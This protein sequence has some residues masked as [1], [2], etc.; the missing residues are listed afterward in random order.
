MDR[1]H[2]LTSHILTPI[3]YQGTFIAEKFD[4]TE[5]SKGSCQGRGNIT[6]MMSDIAAKK[7]DIAVKEFDSPP[8]SSSRRQGIRLTAK[9]EPQPRS[10]Q[11]EAAKAGEPERNRRTAGTQE[12][13][14]TRTGEK[15]RT[16]D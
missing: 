7:S 15:Q 8:R 5:L 12:T 2:T 6:A 3:M 9:E 4:A 11:R 16:C 13:T 1:S 10:Y 14:N